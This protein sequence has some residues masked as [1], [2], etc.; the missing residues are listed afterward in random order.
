[1]EE[2]K[3]RNIGVSFLQIPLPPKVGEEGTVCHPQHNFSPRLSAS[4]VFDYF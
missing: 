4:A 2:V 1:L 3:V